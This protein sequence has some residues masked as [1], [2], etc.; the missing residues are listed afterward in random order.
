VKLPLLFLLVNKDFFLENNKG[1][2]L[3]DPY[4]LSTI[5]YLI[6]YTVCVTILFILLSEYQFSN[7]AEYTCLVLLLL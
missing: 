4:L 7:E 1:S 2:R 5:I 3:M 6:H